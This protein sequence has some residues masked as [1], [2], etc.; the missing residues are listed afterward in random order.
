VA[1]SRA[2]MIRRPEMLSCGVAY[3]ASP[4]S[5]WAPL[6]DEKM[7]VIERRYIDPRG[8][9]DRRRKLEHT[10][11]Q[12]PRVNVPLAEATIEQFLGQRKN[13]ATDGTEQLRINLF[14]A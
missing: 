5:H 4:T 3:P 9:V 8:S 2:K 1:I 7:W 10:E 13:A 14:F 6:C 11:K 12:P